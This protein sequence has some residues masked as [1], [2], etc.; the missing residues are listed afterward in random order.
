MS[1]RRSRKNQRGAAVFIVVMVV[2]LLTAIGV[3]A[4]RSSSLVDVAV[5]YDRQAVQA[6]LLSDYGGRLAVAELT[7]PAKAST[8]NRALQ[9]QRDSPDKEPCPSNAAVDRN[10]L[11]MAPACYKFSGLYLN[12]LV[13]QQNSAISL[14]ET[15]GTDTPGS[16]GPPLGLDAQDR[17]VNTSAGSLL[18]E[19]LESYQ[20]L[21]PPPG[22]D[23][24]NTSRSPRAVQFTLTSWAQ[25]RNIAASAQGANQLWCASDA[26]S[27]SSASVQ[28]V[29]A[30]VT[31]PL[32]NP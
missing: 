15:Q 5:G 8:Y 28:R 2:T 13:Q 10:A 11:N 21:E 30:Y 9:E 14:L 20:T 18:V 3:F 27:S 25:V 32:V 26:Q 22:V 7:D 6:Q 24:G 4:A 12:Q 31:A 16:L 29:R 17:S 1:P 23:V 19:V